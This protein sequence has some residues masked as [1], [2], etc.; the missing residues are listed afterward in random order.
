MMKH[1]SRAA[2]LGTTMAAAFGFYACGDDS[3]SGPSNSGNEVTSTSFK[4]IVDDKSQTISLSGEGF[5]ENMCIVSGETVQWKPV[6]T[7][8]GDMIAKYMFVG[9][10]LVLFWQ[11]EDGDF[12]NRGDMFVGGSAGSVYGTWNMVPCEYKESRGSSRCDED[13][14]EYNTT[15]SISNGAVNITQTKQTFAE[16]STLDYS[17]SEYRWSL[18]VA[19][20]TGVASNLDPTDL[21][22]NTLSE[23]GPFA[24]KPEVQAALGIVS[25]DL[26]T[27]GE[28]ISIAGKTFTVKVKD[29]QTFI[30][31]DNNGASVDI[32]ADGVTCNSTVERIYDLTSDYCKAENMDYFDTD[33]DFDANGNKYYYV[34]RY[35]K[36][37]MDEFYA[38]MQ[39]IMP[40]PSGTEEDLWSK[41]VTPLYKK[42][43][44]QDDIKAILKKSQKRLSRLAK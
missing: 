42:T 21:S 18:Y 13:D 10:T 34:D 15:L 30:G 9:D 41:V 4:L 17:T 33:Y 22:Y 27:T 20:Y 44:E 24:S 37:N 2:L 12:E 19:L 29:F 36:S 25:S 26:S 39:G 16:A 6:Q 23:A 43:A 14:L 3:S 28:T 7:S 38:C 1:L 40:P 11:D 5:K 32:S 35:K 8:P 31:N